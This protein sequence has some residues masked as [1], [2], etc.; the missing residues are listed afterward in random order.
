MNMNQQAN[1]FNF[2]LLIWN[3]TAYIKIVFLKKQFVDKYLCQI[4]Y[5]FFI[6]LQLLLEG[7]N[8]EWKRSLIL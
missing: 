8:P 6:V 3:L 5:N 4:K 2:R 7:R 1:K